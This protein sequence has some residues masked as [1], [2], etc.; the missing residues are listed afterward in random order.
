MGS[1]KSFFLLFRLLEN[2]TKYLKIQ[3]NIRVPRNTYGMLDGNQTHL[4]RV[5]LVESINY[6]IPNLS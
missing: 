4:S 3:S 5:S 2:V 1:D 6:A